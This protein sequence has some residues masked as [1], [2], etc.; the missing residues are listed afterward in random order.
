MDYYFLTINREHQF[1]VA[2]VEV[3]IKFILEMEQIVPFVG[4]IIVQLVKLFYK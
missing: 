2:K 1:S 4:Q 3:T